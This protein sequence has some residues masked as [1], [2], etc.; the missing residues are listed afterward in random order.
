MGLVLESPVPRQ[1]GPSPVPSGLPLPPALPRVA[2]GT[3]GWCLGG[4]QGVPWHGTVPSLRA[5]L[6]RPRRQQRKALRVSEEPVGHC[7]G[8]EKV[9]AVE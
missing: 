4:A 2:A 1:K 6:D 8:P 7:Q 9:F 5:A 3:P